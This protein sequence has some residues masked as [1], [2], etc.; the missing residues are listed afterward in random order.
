MPS[1][2]TA[3]NG[4][5]ALLSGEFFVT[6]ESELFCDC[7]EE[8]CEECEQ[9]ELYDLQSTCEEPIPWTTIKEIYAKAVEHL[10]QELPNGSNTTCGDSVA[11]CS[12][13]SV[14]PT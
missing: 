13:S 12:E 8:D 4:A 9:T 11:K 10:K 5:K 1:R 14:L 7:G 3:E 2:L 6:V